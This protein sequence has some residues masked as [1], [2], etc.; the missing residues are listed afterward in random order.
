MV[1]STLTIQMIQRNKLC[2]QV[3]FPNCL[4]VRNLSFSTKLVAN[5]CSFDRE[6]RRIMETSEKLFTLNFLLFFYAFHTLV[7][8]I[9][10]NVT[11]G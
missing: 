10:R 11:Q 9:R 6:G 3:G 2:N 5:I 8:K 1:H 7:K 4:S